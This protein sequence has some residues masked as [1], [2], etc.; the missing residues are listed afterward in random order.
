[1]RDT[2]AEMNASAGRASSFLS[3]G[4]TPA[5]RSAAHQKG[6]GSTARR[7][8]LGEARHAKLLA[9]ERQVHET[10]G[11]KLGRHLGASELAHHGFRRDPDLQGPDAH[12]GQPS[13]Q[14]PPGVKELPMTTVNPN[15]ESQRRKRDRAQKQTARAVPK[16]RDVTGLSGTVARATAKARAKGTPEVSRPSATPIRNGPK[17]PET[18]HLQSQQF[19]GGKHHAPSAQG[20]RKNA[21]GAES[22]GSHATDSPIYHALARQTGTSVAPSGKGSSSPAYEATASRM[23]LQGRSTP[24]GPSKAGKHERSYSATTDRLGTSMNSGYTGK[25]RKG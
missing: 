10:A 21:Y 4:R 5:E 17:L 25:H 9:A 7:Y 24:S 15:E 16:G 14:K 11:N 23:R 18:Q 22:K 12:K 6:K 2:N 19:T 13:V 8:K 20:A 1:M 3:G